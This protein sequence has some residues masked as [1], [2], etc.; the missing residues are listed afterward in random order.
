MVTGKVGEERRQCL[1]VLLGKDL[2]GSQKHRLVAVVHRDRASPI[3]A[4]MV[5]PLPTSPCN[6]LFI[7]LG[8]SMS[9]E[10]SRM[11]RTCARVSWNGSESTSVR[12]SE[13]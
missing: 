6:S 8:D 1:I 4:T 3:N 13:L 11:T 9:P 2:G 10:I 12:A 5:F 7:G